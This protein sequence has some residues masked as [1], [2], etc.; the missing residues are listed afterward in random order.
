MA[1]VDKHA[2]ITMGGWVEGRAAYITAYVAGVEF[3]VGRV[4]IGRD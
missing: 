2:T 4:C 3:G 1:L